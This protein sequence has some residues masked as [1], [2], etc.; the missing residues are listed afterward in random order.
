MT[1]LTAI[2][3]MSGASADGVGGAIVKTDGE[4]AVDIIAHRFHAYDRD[5][6][7]VLHR[8]AKAAGEG[9]DGA[10]DIG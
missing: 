7:I 3:L 2:G 8:A 4:S 6:K 9:R 5:M 1:V 10:A